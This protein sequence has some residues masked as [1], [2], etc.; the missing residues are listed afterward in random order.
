MK[1]SRT[2]KLCLTALM[3]SLIAV[4]AFLKIPV[5]VIPITI[6]TQVV[7]M[8]GL[9]AGSKV[10]ACAAGVYI[11]MGLLGLPVFAQGGGIH[12]VL[13]PTFGYLLGFVGGAFVSGFIF[14]KKKTAVACFLGAYIGLAVIY[15]CGIAYLYIISRAVL[16]ATIS[17]KATVFAAALPL[18]KDIPFTAA[19]LVYAMRIRRYIES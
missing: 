17:L 14:N 4:A 12:Y 10:G 1:K 8:A 9:I 19:A 18:I 13:N 5:P 3:A 6:Q 2:Y 7:L 16:M 11:L 15:V